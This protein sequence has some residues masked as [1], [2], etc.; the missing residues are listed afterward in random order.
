MEKGPSLWACFLSYKRKIVIPAPKGKYEGG[1]CGPGGHRGWESLVP[2]HG[3]GTGGGE[4]KGGLR[5]RARVLAS[6]WR[7]W[8]AKGF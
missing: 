8:G 1:L 3:E 4:A 5:P 6:F 7:G 2:A